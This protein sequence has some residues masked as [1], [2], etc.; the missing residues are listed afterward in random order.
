MPHPP[1]C[2]ASVRVLTSQPFVALPSQSPKGAVHVATV[3]VPLVHAREAL[4]VMHARLHAP[5]WAVLRWGSMHAPPQ[6]LW[7]VGH[8]RVSLQPGTH[9]L[10]TQSDPAAQCSSR[11]HSTQACVAVS[12]RRATPAS[13][14]AHPSSER[15]P[16]TQVFEASSQCCAGS[17]VSAAARHCTQRPR[18]ASHTEPMGLPAHSLFEKQRAGPV[19]TGTSTVT[20]GLTSGATS[21][22]TSGLTSGIA[23]AVSTVASVRPPTT[24]LLDSL[25]AARAAKKA[26]QRRN[27]MVRDAIA[28]LRTPRA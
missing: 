10:P 2:D 20:S 1:Q 25:H 4:A 14:P 7:P 9:T 5:Q 27:F 15:H 11:T 13:E 3:H 19:S 8:A 22:A 24:A 17:Q 12:Q 6:Q 28:A 21:R 23:S 26:L 18:A 16:A